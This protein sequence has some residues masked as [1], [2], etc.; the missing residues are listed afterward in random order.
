MKKNVINYFIDVGLIITFLISFITALIKFP[1]LLQ[2]LGINQHM[3][4]LNRVSIIHDWSGILMSALVMAHLFL[5]WCRV[6]TMTKTILFKKTRIIIVTFSLIVV[7]LAAF[8][9]T[10][11]SQ[12]PH[13]SDL[14]P[15]HSLEG[16][17]IYGEINNSESNLPSTIR[18]GSTAYHFDPRE[19]ASVRTDIFR[20]GH[21]S[22]FAILVHL[23]TNGTIDLEY[24]Y[25][26]TLDTHVIDS[27]NDQKDWWYTAYYDGGWPERNV[28]RMDHFPYKDEMHIEIHEEDN[29]ILEKI[30]QTF[31]EERERIQGNEQI[32]IPVVIIRGLTT[33]LRFETVEVTAHNL[34][35]DYFQDGVITAIDVILS[36]GDQ[37]LLTYDLQWYDS[38]GTAEIVRS[39]WVNRIDEDASYGRCGFVYEIGSFDYRGF[40]GNHI[41]IPSDLRVMTSPEYVEFFWICL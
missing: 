8:I 7:F 31:K 26:E 15:T 17:Q 38:I 35:S 12:T 11:P 14:N 9:I 28:F 36:L 23:D 3:L 25:D 19:V 6:W 22:V 20:E 34:R 2:K 33:D 10:S 32:I 30:Y 39:Y 13:E 37:G 29:Q 1:G 41:H 16:N 40:K 5:L 27:I 24:H 21:F 4:P 18:I